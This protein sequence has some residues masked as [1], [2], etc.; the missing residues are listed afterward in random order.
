[1]LGVAGSWSE[2]DKQELVRLVELHRPHGA[3][4]WEVVADK[5]GRWSRGGASAERM[6]RTLTDPGYQKSTNKH[7]RR[8]NPRRGTPMHIMALC[9]LRALPGQQGTLSQIASAIRQH[10][11][12]GLELDWSP[13]PGTKTY[14]RWKDALVGCFKRGRYPH[15]SK[16]RAREVGMSLYRLD[17]ARITQAVQLELA[18]W[19]ASSAAVLAVAPLAGEGPSQAPKLWLLLLCPRLH[20]K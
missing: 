2:E 17:P 8:L 3:S 14:P 18:K 5:L 11:A 1:M 4:E 10:P 16:T 7:G 9:A 13:R 12:H 15:L 19:E 6:Y 20:G